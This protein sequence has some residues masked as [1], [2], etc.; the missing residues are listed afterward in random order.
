[1]RR[2]GGLA[3]LNCPVVSR[4][5]Q[6]RGKYRDRAEGIANIKIELSKLDSDVWPGMLD[7]ERDKLMLINEKEELLKELQ[8]VTLRKYSRDDLMRLEAERKRLEEE[9]HSAP[10][11]PSEALAERLK[12]HEKRKRLVQHLEDTTQ[13][14]MYLH[15]QLK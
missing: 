2:L 12:L 1:M 15:S 7:V 8:F 10:N 5:V 11:T 14:I 9:L 4:D 6:V 13:L 3:M